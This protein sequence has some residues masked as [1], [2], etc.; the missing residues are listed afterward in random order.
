MSERFYPQY[1]LTRTS[2]G[3]ITPTPDPEPTYPVPWVE[4]LSPPPEAIPIEV[5]VKAGE[6]LYLPAGWWHRVSQFP[7]PGGLAVAVN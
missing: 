1:T 2:D 6:T 7:G 5:E 4:S 3:S